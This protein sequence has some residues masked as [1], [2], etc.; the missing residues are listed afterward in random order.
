VFVLLSSVIV[1]P[2]RAA[3]DKG[4][5]G[6]EVCTPCHRQIAATQSHTNMARAWQGASPAQL[7]PDYSETFTEG[8]DPAIHYALRKSGGNFQFQVQMP[9]RPQLDFPVETTIG[10]ERHGVSFVVRVSEIEGF[11]LPK[12]ALIEAR[13]FHYREQNRLA[14]ELGFPGDK[15]STYETAF[16]RVL[17]PYLEKQCFTCHGAP[18]TLG[19][20]VE[21]GVTCESCHGPG[22]AHLAALGA[23]SKDLRILNPKKLAVAER[24]Q[25]CTQ[26]HAGSSV[27]EDPMPDDTFISNQVTAL[28]N[29]ECW[30]QSGGGFDCTDCHDPHADAPRATVE[31]RSEKTCLRC[32]STTLTNRAAS[33]P[34]NRTTGC[35]ACHLPDVTLGAF[36]MADH[37]I[38]V[39]DE[40]K[41][42]AP[43]H[44]P[45][46]RSK[47][48]PRRLYLRQIVLDDREKAAAI[49]EQLRAGAPF[50]DLARAN[51]IDRATG[52]NGGYLGDLESKDFDPAW[53]ATALRLQPGEVS[54]VVE[55]N[56]KYYMLQRM[57]RNFRMEAEAVFNQAM[58]LRKQGKQ[59]DAMTK[60]LEALKIYPRL[61]RGLTW[62]GA[63]YGQGG[64]APV[65]A[66]ILEIATKLY[67]NDGGA[68]YNLA[69]AYGAMGK[70]EEISEY[71][72]ALQIDPDL[73][74][75][76]LNWGGALYEK[77][78]YEEAIKIYR[79][80]IKVNPLFASL[81]YSL[82]VALEQ[83][84]KTAEAEAEMALAKK[85]DPNVGSR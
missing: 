25:P 74:G 46:W 64:N 52:A 27:V 84:K 50:F 53:S 51:S 70:A 6:S 5:L 9:G 17:T 78:Q 2:L 45:A 19:T 62:L 75:A 79:E 21:K 81:H 3:T 38:R 12:P 69:L 26:C 49:H 22:Q 54:D 39:H 76:Y 42:A 44:D 43:S 55:G 33:C 1:S 63:M 85:I 71:R 82:A 83:Q 29:T 18:R 13:Y 65:S 11:P 66:G 4:Y 61:L 15:P 34:V 23:H 35:V 59:Q 20:H 47:I 16:G 14:L 41:V 40:Q 31:A 32:H 30:R 48:I 72:R 67:P 8:P 73:F 10:G 57:P 77:G 28:H 37:W 58:D 56:G 36:I 24:M 68:H 80:G 60:L 7:A